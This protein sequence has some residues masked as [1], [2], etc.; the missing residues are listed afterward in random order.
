[1]YPYTA[2]VEIFKIFKIIL[3]LRHG[4]SWRSRKLE[5]DNDVSSSGR[6]LKEKDI[7]PKDKQTEQSIMNLA[8]NVQWTVALVPLPLLGIITNLFHNSFTLFKHDNT[9]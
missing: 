1:M 8:E 2:T 9:F 7:I 4:A 5:I 3:S 6:Q